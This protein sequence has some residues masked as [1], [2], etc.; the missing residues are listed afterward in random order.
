MS[1]LHRLLDYDGTLVPLARYP[2][3]ATPDR[4]LL[5]LLSALAASPQIELEI[6][7][8][9]T[10]ETIDKWFAELPVSLW[11]EHGFWHRPEKAAAWGAARTGTPN[12]CACVHRFSSDSSPARPALGWRSRAHQS[13][14]TIGARRMKSVRARLPRC[15]IGSGMR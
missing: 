6:V 4:A 7:S 12:G 9:R 8:G 11:A 5:P 10:R 3:L 14:G 1:G 15:E 13:L 2:E